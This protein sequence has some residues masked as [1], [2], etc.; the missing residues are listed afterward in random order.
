MTENYIESAV[1][2]SEKNKNSEKVFEG[3]QILQ[4]AKLATLFDPRDKKSKLFETERAVSL[5][6]IL[7]NV[8]AILI[9]LH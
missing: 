3:H 5:K 1:N 2:A 9:V 7:G 4:A 6:S 8:I